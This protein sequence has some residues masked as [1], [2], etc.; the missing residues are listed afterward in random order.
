MSQPKYSVIIPVYNRPDEVD[1]LLESLTNQKFSDFEV[2]IVED[3]STHSCKEVVDRYIDKLNISY[4]FKENTGPGTTRNFGAEKAK[5]EFFIFFDSDCIIPSDYFIEVE[6]ELST[7]KVDAFGGPDRSHISFTPIQ[8][9]I[10]YSMTSFFT[11]GGIRG[12]KERFDKFFPRSFNMGIS[13][14][15]F[16]STGGFSKLRFGEDVDFSLRIVHAGFKTRLFPKAWVYHK[17]RTDFRKFYRQ[18]YNSGIARINLHLL[19]P[20]SLKIV[21]LLPSAFVVTMIFF[22]L[23]ATFFPFALLLPIGYCLIV[24]ISSLILNGNLL[25]A[26]LSIPASWIQLFGYGLGFIEATWKRLVLGKKDFKAFEKN[27]YS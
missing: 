9:A 18:V 2:I 3:G 11:T 19:H 7:G 17:R 6:Q 22:T 8:K 24:F 5:G 21:H 15:A 1:E 13:K 20:G 23:A 4:F 14:F 10:N 12:G 16:Q 25:V 27:F 26:F